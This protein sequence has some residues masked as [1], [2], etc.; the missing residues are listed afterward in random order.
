MCDV[1]NNIDNGR[2]SDGKECRCCDSLKVDLE[3]V[4]MELASA[5]EIIRIMKEDFASALLQVRNSTGTL[6]GKGGVGK[7]TEWVEVRPRGVDLINKDKNDLLEKAN[8]KLPVSNRYS[9]LKESDTEEE[10]SASTS[11]GGIVDIETSYR[12]LN[13]QKKELLSV[14]SDM[15]HGSKE[16]IGVRIPIIINGVEDK[17]GNNDTLPR[18][19]TNRKKSASTSSFISTSKKHHKV[20]VLGDSY[21]KGCINKLIGELSVNFKVSGIIRSG[22]GVDKIV[23]S[24]FEDMRKLH[25]QDVIVLNAGS[26]DVYRNNVK[27][28][29]TLITKFIQE[30]YGTNIIILELPHRHD[31]L[32]TSCV[33]LEIKEFNKRLKKIVNAYNHVTLLETSRVRESFTRHGA[34]WNSYGKGLAM[35]LLA[36]QINK[37]IEKGSQTPINL[38]WKDNA[39][40]S[41]SS[42]LKEGRNTVCD[43]VKVNINV[44][45]KNGKDME[46]IKQQNCAISKDG[47][48]PQRTSNRQKKVPITRKEDF[49]W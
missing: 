26:N 1:V 23:N 32:Y 15:S 47:K 11:N 39:C 6:Q 4:I 35:K 33:N 13:V 7:N 34:H 49:L 9:V 29:L 18:S 8:I 43:S 10:L 21:L 24:S 48:N 16:K 20:L 22:A 27:M 28:A 40:V 31:L 37:V 14:E 19:Q 5:M 45:S 38:Y 42:S 44:T 25:H 36:Q 2:A 30:N 41:N 12:D 17:T 46:Q 3:N